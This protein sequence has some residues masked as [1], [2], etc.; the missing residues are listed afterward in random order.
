[1]LAAANKRAAELEVRAEL[2][3]MGVPVEVDPGEALLA[4]VYEAAG[5]VA[6]LRHRVQQLEQDQLYA[7]IKP[8]E[9]KA[10]PHV[11]VRMYDAERD[12]LTNCSALAVRNGI[13]ERR[14]RMAEATGG[15][16]FDAVSA[17]LNAAGLTPEQQEAFRRAL[18]AELRRSA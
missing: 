4:M 3:K 9:N 14:V 7:R 17:A 2:Q 12:R 1:M 16:L 13:E 15:R 10:E 18:A 6:Y 11:L 5:N 8:D